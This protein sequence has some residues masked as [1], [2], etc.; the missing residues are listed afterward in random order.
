VTILQLQAQGAGL[1]VPPQLMTA[2]PYLACIIVLVLISRK[3]G[4][5]GSTAPAS[6]GLVFVPD[7]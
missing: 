6:L 2:L 5:A 3:R 1:A 4:S 7:R